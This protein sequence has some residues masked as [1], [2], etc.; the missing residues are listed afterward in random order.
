M[1]GP[2]LTL[3]VFIQIKISSTPLFLL[4]VLVVMSTTIYVCVS[5][6]VLIGLMS[7]DHFLSRTCLKTQWFILMD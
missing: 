6:F 4:L 3:V 2:D 5:V 1:N 7:Y